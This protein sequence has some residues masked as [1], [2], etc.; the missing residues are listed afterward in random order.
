MF[1][2]GVR[3]RPSGSIVVNAGLH[4]SSLFEILNVAYLCVSIAVSGLL[5]EQMGIAQALKVDKCNIRFEAAEI[6]LFLFIFYFR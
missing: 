1:P 4:L 6:G 2:N 3:E 5:W